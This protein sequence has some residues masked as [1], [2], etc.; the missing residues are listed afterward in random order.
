MYV[1]RLP[2]PVRVLRSLS[3]RR[4]AV[5][6]LIMYT[7]S[8]PTCIFS[9]DDIF[10]NCTRFFGSAA[11]N[12]SQHNVFSLREGRGLTVN[13]GIG[14]L[15]LDVHRPCM[16]MPRFVSPHRDTFYLKLVLC[17]SYC[18]TPMLPGLFVVDI[19]RLPS[20]HD[21]LPLTYLYYPTT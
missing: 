6:S 5:S 8:T 21:I 13:C 12:V 9:R 2:P 3:P 10:Y 15:A 18:P 11:V 19:S 14:V 20:Y 7:K 16:D 1:A 4:S 17:F